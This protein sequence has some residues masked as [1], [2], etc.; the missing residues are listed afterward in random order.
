[1]S[2]SI[3]QQIRELDQRTKTQMHITRMIIEVQVERYAEAE[4]L[5]LTARE[6]VKSQWQHR[7]SDK[8]GGCTAVSQSKLEELEKALKGLRTFKIPARILRGLEKASRR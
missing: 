1:M 3:K 5:R 4:L 8:V 6:L 7:C 2:K